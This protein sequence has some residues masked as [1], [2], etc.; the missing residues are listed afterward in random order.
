MK[1]IL[2][3]ALI[4][5]AAVSV[6]AWQQNWIRWK[7]YSDPWQGIFTSPV[8]VTGGQGQLMWLS[9]SLSNQYSF[10]LLDDLIQSTKT[11]RFLTDAFHM[12]SIRTEWV[13]AAYQSGNKA[14]DLLLILYADGIHSLKPE[15]HLPNPDSVSAII[16]ERRS[17]KDLIY[18]I[19]YDDLKLYLARKDDLI[20]ISESSFLVENALN[21]LEEKNGISV[22]EGFQ[23]VHSAP[24][25]GNKFYLYLPSMLSYLQTKG[26]FPVFPGQELNPPAGWAVLQCK[27]STGMLLIDGYMEAGTNNQTLHPYLSTASGKSGLSSVLPAETDFVWERMPGQEFRTI[28][29]GDQLA[30]DEY[31]NYWNDWVGSSWATAASMFRDTSIHFEQIF[32][33]STRKTDALD[34]LTPIMDAEPLNYREKLVYR[35]APSS[36]LRSMAGISDSTFCTRID[37]YL[38]FSPYL[39]SIEDCIDAGWSR[40]VLADRSAMKLIDSVQLS[41]WNQL[42]FLDLDAWSNLF[43]E[44]VRDQLVFSDK[45]NPLVVQMNPHNGLF[46]INAY[47]PAAVEEEPGGSWAVE[48][49]APVMNGPVALYNQLTETDC[50]V[51]QDSLNQ[52]YLIDTKGRLLWKKALEQP[53]VGNISTVDFYN[54][55]KYQLLFATS[56]AIQLVDMKGND[57]EGFPIRISAPVTSGLSAIDYEHDGDYRMFAGC[58][59]GNTYGFYRNGKP[60]TGWKPLKTGVVTTRVMHCSSNGKDYLYF[61]TE[62]NELQVRSRSG[63]L[64][65]PP[66]SVPPDRL[67]DPVPDKTREPDG[68]ILMKKGG[69]L[70][71]IN[72]NGDATVI[73]F[74][75]DAH[76]ALAADINGDGQTDIIYANSAGIFAV[77]QTGKVLFHTDPG[78]PLACTL[79]LL[80]GANGYRILVN[81][82]TTAQSYLLDEHGNLIETDPFPMSGKAAW[83]SKPL[84]ILVVSDG[85]LLQSYRVE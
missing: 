20:M 30:L 46:L 24:V 52:L 4:V 3:A 58:S 56:H 16:E 9:D 6:I 5:L 25:E 67:F 36:V 12:D 75:T 83:T 85:Q 2:G 7:K 34:R 10:P 41:A 61:L 64:R 53:L 43:D 60:L 39:S 14:P 55:R 8:L 48:L 62:T 37:D 15:Q 63:D 49:D 28:L 74:A 50:F 44:P 59:N 68:L 33:V 69:E 57:V 82:T 27:E 51:L 54:N 13:L 71:K 11:L 84:P 26:R 23:A 22:D 40:S 35:M 18:H 19:T 42:L 45:I 80:N 65:F 31:Q 70:M 78:D 79:Q 17:G 38:L 72:W 21:C 29:Q 77:E 66:S 1:K 47:L 76:H 32:A 81:V 73:P